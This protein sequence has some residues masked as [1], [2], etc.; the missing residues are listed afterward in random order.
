[1]TYAKNA[2]DFSERMVRFIT[3]ARDHIEGV[4]RP[5]IAG[6]RIP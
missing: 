5:G 2:D 4:N 6:D 3:H 1:M